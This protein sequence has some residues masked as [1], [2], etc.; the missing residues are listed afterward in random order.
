MQQTARR[1]GLNEYSERGP[2]AVPGGRFD[3]ESRSLNTRYALRRRFAPPR[4]P[5]GLD[6]LTYWFLL[7]KN[8]GAHLARPGWARQTSHILKRYVTYCLMH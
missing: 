8:Q 5:F 4:P 6:A 7:H 2:P 3:A 1:K